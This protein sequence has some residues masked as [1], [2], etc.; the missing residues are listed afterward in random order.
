MLVVSWLDLR[1]EV[2]TRVDVSWRKYKRYQ[3]HSASIVV[4]VILES[5]Y[6]SLRRAA[7]HF[8]GPPEFFVCLT[9]RVSLQVIQK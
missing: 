9:E 5:R 7:Q 3:C 8:V 1:L 6:L 2:R 4:E